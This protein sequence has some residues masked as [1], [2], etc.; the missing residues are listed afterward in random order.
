MSYNT[1]QN[2]FIKRSPI[3]K[4]K[5]VYMVFFLSVDEIQC[6]MVFV[7]FSLLYLNLLRHIFVYIGL[8]CVHVVDAVAQK[9]PFI[10]TK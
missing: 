8:A 9:N 7:L 1:A 6:K 4:R 3:D 10:K 2:A 5:Q